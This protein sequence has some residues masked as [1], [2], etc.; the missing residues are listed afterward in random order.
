MTRTPLSLLLE[1]LIRLYRF[2]PKLGDHC[3]YHPSCSA[4]GLEAVRIHGGI[5]GGWL[6]IRRIGRCQP[7]GGTGLDPV[8]PGHARARAQDDDTSHA[9]TPN[10]AESSQ[11]LTRQRSS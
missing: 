4:Y 8:P 10:G 6:T 3:R 7:W 11:G 2:V 9:I 1:G 5:K